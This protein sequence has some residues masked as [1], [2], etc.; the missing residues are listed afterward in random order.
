MKTPKFIIPTHAQLKQGIRSRRTGLAAPV[1]FALG[2]HLLLFSGLLAH[3]WIREQ[4]LPA[5]AMTVSKNTSPLA[6]A[7]A[8]EPAGSP[9]TL[10]QGLPQGPSPTNTPEG[11]PARQA[12]E[13]LVYEA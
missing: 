6:K 10:V 5:L 8:Q 12:A 4:G 2:V 9:D 3:G 1:A 13:G 7:G 11:T